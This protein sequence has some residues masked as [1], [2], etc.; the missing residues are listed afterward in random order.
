[1]ALWEASAAAREAFGADIVGH[2]ATAARAELAAY[3]REVTDWERRRGFER[4]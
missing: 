1:V 4:L 2:Y 3:Q